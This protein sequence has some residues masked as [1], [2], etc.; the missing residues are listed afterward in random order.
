MII[1]GVVGFVAVR[2]DAS[3][4]DVVSLKKIERRVRRLYQRPGMWKATDRRHSELA[5]LLEQ[6][7]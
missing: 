3:T 6:A 4:R 1:D 5:D 2:L 7:R